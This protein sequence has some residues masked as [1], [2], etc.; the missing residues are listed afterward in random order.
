MPGF[1]Y[2]DQL[3]DT[4]QIV[5][6]VY[7]NIASHGGDPKRI[8]ISGH[9][10]GAMLTTQAGVNTAWLTSLSLPGDII[11]GCAR[12]SGSY[13][14]G[15]RTSDYVPDESRRAEANPLANITKPAPRWVIAVG[16]AEASTPSILPEDS[17]AFGARLP[18]KGVAA[19]VMMLEG[20]NHSQTALVLAD[21]QSGLVQ[22]ILKMI[23]ATP[24]S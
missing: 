16:S 6:W 7:R 19:D 9:S 4:R 11:K 18:E 21:E 15:Q 1:H 13:D 17:L 10:A 8:Y 20:L 3:E 24:G 5:T 12:I 14:L 23:Q 2:P 22:A